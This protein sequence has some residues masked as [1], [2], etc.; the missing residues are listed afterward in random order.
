MKKLIDWLATLLFLPIF[1]IEFIFFDVLQRIACL[2]GKD[3]HE[4]SARLMHWSFLNS[5]RLIGT[6]FEYKGLDN[7]PQQ[8]SIILVANHQS[9]FDIPLLANLIYRH[10]PRFIAKTALA[11]WI[12]SASF[13]LRKAEHA[14]IKRTDPRQSLR[15]IMSLG[16]KID[17]GLVSGVIFP[18][19]TR[20]R[21]GQLKKFHHAGVAALLKAAPNA[22][23]LPVTL[24]GTWELSKHKC[25]P[26]PSF[27]KVK[28]EVHET[29]SV[30]EISSSK[31]FVS[32]LENKF[33]KSLKELRAG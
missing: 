11:R 24:D 19:G 32:E 33:T 31:E 27:V 30:S 14:V 15:E 5:L 25:M 22:T 23:I 18:E 8:G 16:E 17:Q 20:A 13:N 26:F 12:P 10:K 9:I 2:F 28:V 1:I 6:S 29:K 4:Y 7:I 3:A 21:D